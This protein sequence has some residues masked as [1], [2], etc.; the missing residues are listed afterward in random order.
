MMVLAMVDWGAGNYERTAAELEP[1]A[2][3][4]VTRASLRPGE[5]VVDLACGTGNAALLAAALGTEVVGIDSASRL[6]EAARDSAHARRLAID[7]R[8]GDLL[9]LPLDDDG[10]DVLLSVF[11]VIFAADP[12]RALSEVARVVRPGGRVLVSA[13]VP[14]GP[15]DAM[16][17]AMGSVLARVTQAAPPPRFAWYDPAAVDPVAERAGL[18]LERTTEAALAITDSSP[19]AYVAAGTEHPM[20][21]ATRPALEGAGLAEEA[22]TAMI[23]VLREANQDPDALL[24]HSPYVVHELRVVG[25][26]EQRG[27]G[28]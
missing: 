14:T 5:R 19:E 28:A 20:S 26:R 9:D 2:Q 8:E 3:A 12:H 25:S 1:V 11:G 6:L 13:W 21:L 4:I 24:V 18:T 17:T 27:D 16:L 10:A 7:F 15:I 23:A 22:Q